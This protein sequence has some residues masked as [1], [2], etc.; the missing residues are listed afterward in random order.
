[1]A[2]AAARAMQ[3]RGG[4]A[5]VQ[6]GSLWAIQAIGATPYAVYSAAMLFLASAITCTLLPVD[7]GVIAGRIYV[8]PRLKF[9]RNWP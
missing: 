7:D 5:I 9:V 3:L 8:Q 6:I 1:M 2:Q 4:G